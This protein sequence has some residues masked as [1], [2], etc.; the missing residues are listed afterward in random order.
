MK[1]V[2]IFWSAVL[3]TGT[4]CGREFFVSPAGNNKNPGTAQ[5]PFATIGKAASVVLP[6]DTVKIGPGLYREQITFKRSGKP[7][8]P[9][10]FAGTRGP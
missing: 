9:I 6:G 4:L 8:A 10:V 2:N 1:I 7:G 5:A 3:L